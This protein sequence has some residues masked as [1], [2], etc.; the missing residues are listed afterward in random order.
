MK[1]RSNP[2]THT[3]YCDGQNTP[4]EMVL[5][6]VGQGFSSLG[7]SGHSYTPFDKSCS[8][9]ESG[10]AAYRKEVSTL[11]GL[12]RTQIELFLGIEWDYYSQIDRG[13]YDYTIG[14]VHY[15][16]GDSGKFY[17][18]ENTPEEM[19]EAVNLL[20]GGDGLK[21]AKRY[22]ALLAEMALKNR[23]DILGHFDVLKKLNSGNRFFDEDSARYRTAALEAVDAAAEAG[24]I[25]EI[26]T[27]GVYRG[28]RKDPYPSPFLL[29]RMAEKGVP[30]ILSSDAHD[31]GALGFQLEETAELARSCG[32]ASVK[33]L[34]DGGFKDIPLA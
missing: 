9:S 23:P 26:N 28:Y 13:Q 7:F 30:V 4:E 5:A 34:Q 12:Y 25:C 33:V 22:Y 32:F 10:T 11:K 14:S 6:A 15:L 1:I 29:K 16:Q 20:C 3:V 21:L 18:V 24:C 31:P 2:H 8:M 19:Q 17:C 27:G